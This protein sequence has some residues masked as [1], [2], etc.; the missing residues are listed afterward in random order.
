M[1]TYES[2][3]R[4]YLSNTWNFPESEV[5]FGNLGVAYTS[6]GLS[7][8]SND[9]WA[10]AGSL[11]PDYDVPFY[12][13]YS[14]IKSQGMLLIQNG[15]YEQ[16]LQAI[17]SSIPMIERTLAC[18][19]IHYKGDW[20]KE[21]DEMK[22]MVANPTGV[23]VNELARLYQLRI[24]LNKNLSEAKDDKRRGEVI[25]SIQNN[26]TQINNLVAFLSSKGIKVDF[27]AGRGLLSKLTGGM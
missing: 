27:N 2:E 21:R 16:G 14:R 1:P 9:M 12:N 24:S 23:L 11:N 4:F 26:E 3:L 18:K 22:A 7:G 20:T 10:I 6:V 17:T 5:A 8:A 15:A 19:I 13:I 25:P